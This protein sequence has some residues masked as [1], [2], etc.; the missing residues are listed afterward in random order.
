VCRLP[1]HLVTS[2][3]VKFAASRCVGCLGS[4]SLVMAT[5]LQPQCCVRWANI[6]GPEPHTHTRA[7][8][9]VWG[10]GAGG[11][12]DPLR[13]EL[14]SRRCTGIADCF[15]CLS[16]SCQSVLRRHPGLPNQ[17]YRLGKLRTLI[18]ADLSPAAEYM[19]R[20]LRTL[21]GMGTSLLC[22]VAP[23]CTA[24]LVHSCH[25]FRRH[26]RIVGGTWEHPAHA[27]YVPIL[28]LHL[29]SRVSWRNL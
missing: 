27:Y 9:R 13:R 24:V 5:S 10:G 23:A 25:L 3:G 4:W 29:F 6:R 12:A 15:F 19:E 18:G 14:P 8:R 11:N 16:L 20:A 1:G 22:N 17:L 26:A 2:H 7:G 28:G 21:T